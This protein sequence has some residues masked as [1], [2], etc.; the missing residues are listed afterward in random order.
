MRTLVSPAIRKTGLLVITAIVVLASCGGGSTTVHHAGLNS[1][2]FVVPAPHICNATQCYKPPYPAQ[3]SEGTGP[4]KAYDCT[5]NLST[6]AYTGAYGTASAIGWEGNYQGVVTCLGG[7]FYVQD[8][9]DKNFGFGIYHGAQTT[10]ADADGYLP[11]QITTFHKAGV[12][13]SIT[14]FADRLTIGADAYVAVYS[15]VAV[16]NPTN[17]AVAADPEPSPGMVLLDTAPNIVGAHSAVT[18]DYVV[19]VDRFGNTYP[20]P[21]AQALANAGTFDSHFDH[22]RS[23]W[24][25]QLSDIAQIAVPDG[26][27]V[28]AYK[29]G[30]V[31]T[32]IA[33]SGDQ[34]NTGVN[35]YESQFSHD[36][37]GILANLFTQGDYEDAGDLLTDT[38]NVVGSQGQY[39][40]GIWT[41]SWPWA[42]YV[43][44]TGNLAL[45]KANFDTEGPAGR[46]EAS[47]EDTAH[48]IAAARTGPGGIIEATD[49][50][51]TD[52][53]WTVDD[54][55][56][57]MGLAA[58]EYLAG[59]VGDEA[60]K[61]WAAAEYKSLLQATNSTLE[62]TIHQY[63][64][65]YLPCSML[66]PN[67]ENRCSNPEDANWA[68]PFQFG[69]WAWDAQLFG[70][71]IYGPGVQLIDPTY[72]YGFG[73][74][75][76]K[77]PADTFGGYPD[78][79]FSTAYN[80]GY[81]SWGLASSDH[82]DQGILSYEFMIGY[83][84]SGPYSWWES[85]SGPS[86]GT[87]WIGT[88]PTA[89]QGSSPHA[90]GISEANKVLL[91]SLVAQES[92]GDVIV[93]RGIPSQWLSK[94]TAQ[95]SVTGFPTLDG[96]RIDLTISTTGASVSLHLSG[97][98]APGNVLFEL[99][100][101]VGNILSTSAGRIDESSGTVT[102]GPSV[103]SVTVELRRPVS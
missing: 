66:E 92:D 16:S 88:H 76:G 61:Q 9:I 22:M 42:V 56:A 33:R 24:S 47:I 39:D 19:A 80:A 28:D 102:I 57:L 34:L 11:A 20:W 59:R 84:Q 69:K 17:K 40:D 55:E 7:T 74:L 68:A 18:H 67:T 75:V 72:S 81:G 26:Q 38:R 10:W 77:L 48:D 62:T 1:A 78:D 83:D 13:V 52:G 3:L 93:G 51:D 37:I 87:P 94:G 31:Y 32:E 23:F 4:H 99:P 8:G 90:W 36:V 44:K 101:F 45:L 25:R 70:A 64:I 46:S 6:D 15:R 53:Y 65:D 41:Y 82:R 14:E 98:P 91:D 43:M 21:S 73:R 96:E 58:Y 85:S 29:S 60:Q 30:F 95:M 71:S 35:G 54:F 100:S 50:I 86:T 79:Y 27:L 89:G 103:R 12:E 63:G 2:S 97:N 49:D 5:F